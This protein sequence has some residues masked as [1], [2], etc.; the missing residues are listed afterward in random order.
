MKRRGLTEA[1]SSAI[2]RARATTRPS[3][4][5]LPESAHAQNQSILVTALS[6]RVTDNRIERMRTQRESQ[7]GHAV[8]VSPT[9]N[10]P[11]L[12][13]EESE[14]A[15]TRRVSASSACDGVEFPDGWQ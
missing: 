2:K 9:M 14:P 15:V 13:Y 11:T 3:M 7:L 12:E 5:Q 4:R 8:I 6:G 1:A 10:D